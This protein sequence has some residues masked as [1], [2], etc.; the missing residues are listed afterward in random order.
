[1]KYSILDRNIEVKYWDKGDGVIGNLVVLD[2]ETTMISKGASPDYILGQAYS[3]GEIVYLIKRCELKSFL[4]QHL[5][6]NFVF[7]NAA[8]DISVIGKFCQQNF[9]GL[10]KEGKVKDTGIMYKLLNLAI[11]GIIPGQWSL[12]YICEQLLKIEV[13]KSKDLRENWGFY[14]NN[15]EVEYEKIPEKLLKYA[16]S[17][18]VYTYAIYKILHQQIIDFS[19]DFYLSHKIQLMA[20]IALNKVSERGIA[21]D[22]ERRDKILG[23][24]CDRQEKLK[25][26][27]AEHNYLVGQKGVQAQYNLIIRNL[28]IQLPLTR[29]GKVSQKA[30]HLKKFRDKFEFVDNYLSHKEMTNIVRDLEKLN[31]SRLH[32]RFDYLTVTGRTSSS[33]PA[34]QKIPKNFGVRECFIPSEGHCFVIVDY[35]TIELCALA[36]ICIDRYGYSKMG[37]L[38]NKG[39]DLH[40][41]FASKILDKPEPDVSDKERQI[42]K[43]CNFGFPG[44][45]GATT[46]KNY[47]ET[48]FCIEGISDERIEELKNLWTNSFPEMREYFKDPLLG[49]HDFSSL[50]WCDDEKMACHIFKKVITGKKKNDGSD[51]A[52]SV[53]TWAQKIVLPDILSG[54]SASP[55][56]SE[57]DL[58]RL[59]NPPVTT[60][61]GRIRANVRHTERMNTLFQGLA[62]DGAKI[63][64]YRLHLAGHKVVNFV[65]DEFV[66]EV[67][68]SEDLNIVVK[69]IEEITKEAMK[70]VI[71]NVKIGIDVA[72]ADRW[73][74]DAKLIKDEDGNLQ[75]FTKERNGEVENLHSQG[76]AGLSN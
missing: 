50:E 49:L 24:L 5:K 6:E 40:R 56:S 10:I 52:D 76:R 14:L 71:P 32:S 27:S 34:L 62:A 2:T 59:L 41:W 16:A 72:V 43:A 19:P 46:F 17:D 35:N 33:K 30:E 15:G 29:T 69:E 20:S 68:I 74:K 45:M 12:K 64:L 37:D 51:Y 47:A 42:A 61:T 75:I 63:G 9:S 53:K 58:E 3:G 65:H 23:R 11:S 13:D 54:L 57:E 4:Y 44:G 8:F 60:R 55:Q 38:I 25:R 67:P 70:A 21:F 28:G 73:Y 36:Q 48:A 22:M 18:V 66:V 39:K 26:R 1:M 7:H 31:E